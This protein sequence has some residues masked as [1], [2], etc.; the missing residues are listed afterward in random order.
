ML[1]QSD[2]IK[3]HFNERYKDGLRE[4][5][6]WILNSVDLNIHKKSPGMSL[7]IQPFTALYISKCARLLPESYFQQGFRD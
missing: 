6:A 1:L 2:Y 5:E 4:V 3:L 7:P